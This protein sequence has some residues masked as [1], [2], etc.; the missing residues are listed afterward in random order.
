MILLELF[1]KDDEIIDDFLALVPGFDSVN[2]ALEKILVF[3]TWGDWLDS[4]GHKTFLEEAGINTA[5]SSKDAA[6][7]LRI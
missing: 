3:L 1:Q 5:A 4:S 2:D 6:F 7:S